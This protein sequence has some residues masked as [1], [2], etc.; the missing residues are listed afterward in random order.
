MKCARRVKRGAADRHPDV[1][2][3]GRL[4]Q[5]FHQAGLA[6]PGFALDQHDLAAAVATALPG[7]QQQPHLLLAPDEGC[8]A[9]GP[10]CGK[11]ALDIPRRQ[12]APGRHRLGEPLQLI[13]PQILEVEVIAEH[14]ARGRADDDL[15]RLRQCLQ[16]RR[17]VRRLADDRGLRCGSF[18]D[19]VADDHRSGGDADP[20]RELD[21]GRPAG[22]RHSAPPSHRRYRDPPAPNAR[23]RPH[24][25]AGSRNRRGCR[26]PCTSRQSRRSAGSPRCTGSE[27][28]RSHRANLRGP[29]RWRV[30]SIPPGRKTSRSAGGARPGLAPVREA[31]PMPVSLSGL[32]PAR[33]RRA[34][35]WRKGACG[36]GRQGDAEADQ[37]LSRQVRQDVSVDFV[38]AE[39]RLVLSKTELL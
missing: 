19:L 22:L 10:G 8:G 27:T 31:A 26:R 15:V 16:T 21:P 5:S 18:A 23:P 17:Q 11:P 34:R 38:V 14:R 3:A 39:R 37:V 4:P 24:G 33:R 1:V 36:D 12:D 32:G 35:R 30:P 13:G 25:R 9:P 6:D 20:H 28:T 2:L 29:S 7:P